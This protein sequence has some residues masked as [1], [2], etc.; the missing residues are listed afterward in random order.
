MNR[1]R[2]AL[3][4]LAVGGPDY[5]ERMAAFQAQ[6]LNSEAHF[7]VTIDAEGSVSPVGL[8]APTQELASAAARDGIAITGR[9]VAAAFDGAN[10]VAH[11]VLHRLA[12]DTPLAQALARERLELVRAVARAHSA[13]NL[14]ALDALLL[15]FAADPW[16]PASLHDFAVRFAAFA[17][18]S[19]IALGMLKARRVIR[20]AD[21]ASAALSPESRR[22]LELAAGEMADSGAALRTAGTGSF[23]GLDRLADGADVRALSALS[24]SGDGLVLLSW[25]PADAA[26]AGVLA[27]R[28][29]PI[30]IAR[31]ARPALRDHFDRLVHAMP[32]PEAVAPAT[33]PRVARRLLLAAAL[34]AL[35]LPV[36]DRVRAP[37]SIE[38]LVRR[39]VTAPVTA[40][41][42]SVAVEPGDRVPA[43]QILV[44]FDAAQ[45][46]RER[47]EA[48]AGLQA[49]ATQAATAR[50]DGDVEAERIAQLRAAQLAAQVSML[51][52]RLAEAEVRAPIA[53]T[54]NGEDLR[55]RVGATVAR[56]D[57]LYSIAG[58]GGYRAELLVGDSDIARV[59]QGARVSMRLSAAPLSRRSGEITRI[60]P[61]SEVVDGRNIFRTLVSIDADDTAGLRAGMGGSGAITA[62]WSPLAWQAVRP[63]I[64]WIRLKLWV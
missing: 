8:D 25:P 22:S 40:R 59:S 31:L 50:A 5:P 56:G 60:Y 37:L 13:Q 54:V 62:G 44:T 26:L 45:I 48:E 35:L 21:S 17:Q 57:L 61:L 4:S 27:I 63:A 38:P 36:P 15:A 52:A 53:G 46:A 55:R 28:A 24:E 2:V 47:E 12:Q 23:T 14:P 58:S 33:R 49:A 16:S 10:G 20:V 18:T 51:E 9:A 42:E 6:L 39:V 41:I 3:E 34:I 30:A 1:L 64:R 11:V 7:L 32:W 43:G 29:S 19:R